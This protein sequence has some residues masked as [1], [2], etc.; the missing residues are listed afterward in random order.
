MAEKLN[1]EPLALMGSLDQ[2]GDVGHHEAAV[3]APGDHPQVGCEG[4]ERVVRDLGSR[5][6]NRRDQ[7]GFPGIGK[8]HESDIRQQLQLQVKPPLLTRRPGF[9]AGRDSV[10]RGGEIRIPTTT[11]PSTS[12]HL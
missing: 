4:G 9:G 10:G 6:G 7:S 1:A 2:A 12:D 3:L 5:R 11:T 8:P